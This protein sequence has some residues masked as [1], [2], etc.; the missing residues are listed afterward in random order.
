MQASVAK[1]AEGTVYDVGVKIYVFPDAEQLPNPADPG[2]DDGN[3][4]ADFFEFYG[5]L[6][7]DFGDFYLSGMLSWSPEYSGKSGDAIYTSLEGGYQYSDNLTFSA[8]VGLSEFDENLV[9]TDYENY[10]AGATY[11]MGNFDIDVRYHG[12]GS[13][14][15]DT[16]TVVLSIST[17]G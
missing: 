15:D 4:T 9:N 7:Q 13:L 2:F 1:L 11:N 3:S 6:S 14:D 8:G 17:G 5:G 12:T 10:H 16:E